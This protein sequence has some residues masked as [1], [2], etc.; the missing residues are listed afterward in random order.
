VKSVYFLDDESLYVRDVRGHIYGVNLEQKQLSLLE[1]TFDHFAASGTK[2][3]CFSQ[4]SLSAKV[5]K[6]K[7]VSSDRQS[8]TRAKTVPS[9]K[10]PRKAIT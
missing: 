9:K 3:I 7:G 6:K 4:L 10:Q 1:E 2:Y 8:L 5:S